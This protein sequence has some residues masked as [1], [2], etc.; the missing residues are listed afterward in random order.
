M[1]NIILIGLL[2]VIVIFLIAITPAQAH[3]D[4]IYEE[5]GPEYKAKINPIV[6]KPG[7]S[8]CCRPVVSPC[9]WALHCKCECRSLLF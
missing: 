2:L 9:V 7:E 3:I 5:S 8:I 1:K 4:N 6:E